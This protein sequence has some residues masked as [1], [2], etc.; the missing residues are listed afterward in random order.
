GDLIYNVKSSDDPTIKDHR[1]YSPDS[2]AAEWLK[3]Y[4]TR[5]PHEVK[6]AKV[7]IPVIAQT[8]PV[9]ASMLHDTD[10]PATL[11]AKPVKS[12]AIVVKSEAGTVVFYPAR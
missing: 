7:Q 5:I 4:G 10:H 1:A 11:A 8:V 6:P 3:Q 2:Q 12:R 9:M